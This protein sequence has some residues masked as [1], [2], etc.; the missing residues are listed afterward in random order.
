MNKVYKVITTY[1]PGE[2]Y[3]PFYEVIAIFSTKEKAESFVDKIKST[4]AFVRKAILLKEKL[5]DSFDT[6]PI[7]NYPT[8]PLDQA[9]NKSVKIWKN[10]DKQM[11]RYHGKVKQRDEKVS[12]LVKDLITSFNQNEKLY[13]KIIQ[14]DYLNSDDIYSDQIS[15]T[16][17]EVE[18]DYSSI[19]L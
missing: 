4:S 3:N 7:V 11:A 2:P 8:K 12:Q 16:I 17:E 13:D 19:I 5:K 1:D 10:Y 14:T 18:L 15:F 9:D 6:G